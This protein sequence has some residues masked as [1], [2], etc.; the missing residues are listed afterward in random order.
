MAEC[1]VTR[2]RGWGSSEDTCF[3]GGGE[4][5]GTAAECRAVGAPGSVRC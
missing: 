1:R 2:E 3:S 4:W 5:D